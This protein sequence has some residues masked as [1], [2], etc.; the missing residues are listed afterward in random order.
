M[1]K[2]WVNDGTPDDEGNI[3][4]QIINSQGAVVSTFKG[5]TKDEIADA[6]A[7]AQVNANRRLGQLLGKPDK[8]NPPQ[9]E[10][11]SD[12]DRLNY[13]TAIT[14]P[15]KIVE[16]V[17]AIT[18]RRFKTKAEQDAYYN[19]EAI[20]FRQDRPDYDGSDPNGQKLLF[21]KL[22]ENGWDLTRHNLSLALDELIAEGKL[23]LLAHSDAGPQ[24]PPEGASTED[25][26]EPVKPPARR[27]YSTGLRSSDA[28]AQRPAPVQKKPIVTWEILEKMPR[29]E[30]NERIRTDPEFRRAVDALPERRP[31]GAAR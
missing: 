18:D 13:A 2:F 10:P 28:S 30:Y 14:D 27:S 9:G 19:A 6:L 26:P 4:L 7:D 29:A 5:K 23:Q 8:A 11:I 22:L 31:V 15:T 3:T 24:T 20:G 1:R 16:T 12:A 21:E 25:E 17:A